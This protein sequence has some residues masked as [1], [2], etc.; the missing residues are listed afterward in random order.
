MLKFSIKPD[1][2]LR[3]RKSSE[4]VIL[5]MIYILQVK[6]DYPDEFLTSIHGHS[7]SLNE[8]GHLKAME[9]HMDHLVLNKGHV[10]HPQ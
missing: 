8:W 7:G 6:L 4:P 5:V 10:F 9:E 3:P 1:Y 2:Y